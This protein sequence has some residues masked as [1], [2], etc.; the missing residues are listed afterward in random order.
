MC[1]YTIMLPKNFG[2][3]YSRRGFRPSVSSSVSQKW[4]PY[5]DDVLSATFGSLP[6]RS[7]SQH[8]LA[9]KWCQA[10]NFIFWSKILK[11]FHRNDHHIETTCSTQHLSRYLEGQGHSMTLQECRVQPITSL[12]E[13]GFYNHSWQ[14]TFLCPLPIRR[15]LYM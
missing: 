10:H 3:A 11:I 12:F 2:G 4:S 7:R 14:I 8:D 13:V 1:G 6:W 15:A 9:A 5:W